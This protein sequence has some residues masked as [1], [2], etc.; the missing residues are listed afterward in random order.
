MPLFD[1]A[2]FIADIANKSLYKKHDKVFVSS[3]TVRCLIMGEGGRRVCVDVGILLH[4]CY[5]L[6]RWKKEA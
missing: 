3:I 2:R 5:T 1:S 6:S 4:K